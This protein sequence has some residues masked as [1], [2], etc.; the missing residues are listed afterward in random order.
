[1]KILASTVAVLAFVASSAQANLLVASSF[2]RVQNASGLTD[3]YLGAYLQAAIPPN[4]P[5]YSVTNA[6]A[7]PWQLDYVPSG[8]YRNLVCFL[9]EEFGST[10]VTYTESQ[11]DSFMGPR[12]NG[13]WSANLGSGAFSFDT[14]S[15][16]QTASQR[17]YLALTAASV[18]LWNNIAATNATGSFTF[19]LTQSAGSLGLSGGIGLAYIQVGSNFMFATFNANST[20]FTMNITEAVGQNP[21]LY[22]EA[23]TAGTMLNSQYNVR[24]ETESVTAISGAIP[25]PGA[26]ALLGLAGLAGRRRR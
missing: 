19:E 13:T 20:S 17:N 22:L 21:W 26:I 3:G 25:A 7:T 1:M 18:A 23:R 15:V 14:T 11:V 5:G 6:S 4:D 10:Q 9:G 24:Y 2:T 8:A 16:Y 12:T